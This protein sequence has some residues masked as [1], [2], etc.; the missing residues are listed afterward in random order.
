MYVGVRELNAEKPFPKEWLE[1]VRK[2]LSKSAWALG[3]G[4]QQPK[5]I[6]IVL[7]D[8]PKIKWYMA[9]SPITA[10]MQNSVTEKHRKPLN[11]ALGFNSLLNYGFK[12]TEIY[13]RDLGIDHTQLDSFKGEYD[14]GS[15]E[16]KIRKFQKDMEKGKFIDST[17]MPCDTCVDEQQF[18]GCPHCDYN[19]LAEQMQEEWEDDEW[20]E[21][22]SQG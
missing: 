16:K 13:M 4:R 3:V 6:A 21:D 1:K 2:A 9:G 11:D 20:F 15:H 22:Y 8:M 17:G 10:L 19:P 5:K 7:L 14:W 12:N 18:Y